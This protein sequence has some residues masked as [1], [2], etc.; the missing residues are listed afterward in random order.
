MS[1][2]EKQQKSVN[3]DFR[4]DKERIDKEMRE[5]DANVKRWRSQETKVGLEKYSNDWGMFSSEKEF[6]QHYGKKS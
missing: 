1:I 3:K 5:W 2:P 4:K 6:L